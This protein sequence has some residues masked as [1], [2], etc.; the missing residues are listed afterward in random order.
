MKPNPK[1][2]N[3]INKLNLQPHPEG[4]FFKEIHKSTTSVENDGQIYSAFTLIYYLLENQNK[5]YLHRIKFEEA[6]HFLEGDPIEIITLNDMG[7]PKTKILGQNSDSL[8]LDSSVEPQMVISRHTWF[9]ARRLIHPK[10][11]LT[12]YSLVGCTVAPGFEFSDFELATEELLHNF[13]EHANT[14]KNWI[15]P[16]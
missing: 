3:I 7:K 9:G 8:N 12:G 13:S 5:S 14:L 4:G 6:W 1:V 11:P 10:L 15:K 2:Q 16:S